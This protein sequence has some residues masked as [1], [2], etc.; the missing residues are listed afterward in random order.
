MNTIE[1]LEDVLKSRKAYLRTCN[2]VYFMADLETFTPE[3]EWPEDKEYFDDT[4][5]LS[6]DNEQYMMLEPCNRDFHYMRAEK[7]L[8]GLA[9]YLDKDTEGLLLIT[10][11]GDLAHKSLAPHKHVDKV[12]YAKIDGII[13][14]EELRTLENGIILDGVKTKRAIAKLKKT[15]KKN[16]KSYVELTITEGRNHQV[17][18]MFQAVGHKVLKLKRISYSFLNLSNLSTGEYRKLTIKEVKQLYSKTM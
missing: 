8:F 18:N 10:N 13:T 14:R 1:R 16:N 15:D 6:E 7:L 5:D 9:E 17:K 11:N 2:E 3:D 12:Y 4:R